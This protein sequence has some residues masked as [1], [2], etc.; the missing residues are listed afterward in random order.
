MPLKHFSLWCILS[1][2]MLTMGCE[3]SINPLGL[4]QPRMAVYSVLTT[5][6]DTQYV[7]VYSSY[8]HPNNKTSFNPVERSVNDATVTVTDGTNTHI[9]FSASILRP[10][11]GRDTNK[12][13][14]YYAYPFRP[15][16]NKEYTLKVVSST[17]GEVTSKTRVPGKGSIECYTLAELY[18]GSNQPV[19]ALFTLSDLAKAYL[20][21]LYM[22]YTAENPWEPESTR[23]KEKY[24]E[25][26][27]FWKILNL[28]LEH[29]QKQYPEPTRRTSPVNRRDQTHY[30]AAL[31]PY[32]TRQESVYEIVHYNFNVRFKRAVFYLV[33]FDEAWYRYYATVNLFQDR[34]AVRL[35]PPDYSNIQGGYGLFGSFRVD[36][37]VVPLPEYIPPYR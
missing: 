26:P 21:R 8:V 12:I 2:L 17:M 19:A 22:V 3:E 32:P 13:G 29:H 14:L 34:L 11:T 4:F 27:A 7:R 10:D 37:T 18:G 30:L 33:Q 16:E 36:S 1:V 15:Q 6:S 9:F 24:Y 20:V 5:T 31:F 25:V 28:N 23:S 35:D